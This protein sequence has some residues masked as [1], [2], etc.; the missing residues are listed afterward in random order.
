MPVEAPTSSHLAG[1]RPR[2]RRRANPEGRPS[3]SVLCDSQIEALIRIEPFEPGR[4]RAGGTKIQILSTV[5]HCLDENSGS[6]A[7]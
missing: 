7:D 4:K 5:L 2:T 3:M 1:F 6:F